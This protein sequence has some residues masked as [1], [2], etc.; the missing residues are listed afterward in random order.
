MAN[1]SFSSLTEDGKRNIF[2]WTFQNIV[3][4]VFS[5]REIK[6]LAQEVINKCCGQWRK[7]KKI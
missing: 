3:L 2:S 7:V 6:F 4:P 1:T 5:Q